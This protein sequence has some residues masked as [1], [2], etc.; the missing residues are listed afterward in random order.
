MRDA[1]CDRKAQS[2]KT[3]SVTAEQGPVITDHVKKDELQGFALSQAPESLQLV[4]LHPISKKR[5]RLSSGNPHSAQKL[6]SWGDRSFQISFKKVR[7]IFAVADA[8]IRILFSASAGK[9]ETIL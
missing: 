3:G 7:Y 2:L 6:I 8:T 5:T 4:R 9:S 1:E